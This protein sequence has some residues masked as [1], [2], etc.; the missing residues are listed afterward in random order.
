MLIVL[1]IFFG[2]ASLAV[3]VGGVVYVFVRESNDR[4]LMPWGARMRVERAK[5]SL[6]LDAIEVKRLAI[7]D[8]RNRV[9]KAIQED[10]HETVEQLGLPKVPMH[11]DLTR[12]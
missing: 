7:E 5:A 6:E 3:V 10:D 2:L 11:A 9:L 1:S 12:Y 4:P 8:T